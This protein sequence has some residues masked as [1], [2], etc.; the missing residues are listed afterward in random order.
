MSKQILEYVYEHEQQ[1]GDKVYLTQPL[2]NGQV[3]DY[4]WSEVVG[5]ARRMAAHLQAQGFEPGSRIAII[6]K[7]CAHF[8]MAELAIWMAGHV[9]VALYPTVNAETAK[10]VI[11][12]SE[13]SLVFVGKL[14]VWDDIKPGVS[15]DIPHIAFPLAP[16]GHGYTTWD[17][18]TGKT[19]PLDGNPL[20]DPEA[21]GIL[22]YTCL[23]YTSD[24]ADE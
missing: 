21:L 23:L 2:G 17:E 14:D 19:E 1:R 20:P 10:Y 22:I 15:E 24:A 16:S 9:T 18:V 4:T 12:H 7:N 5:Q 3:A 13:A 11:E 6:S 8:I